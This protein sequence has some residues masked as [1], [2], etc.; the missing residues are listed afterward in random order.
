MKVRD[1]IGVVFLSFGISLITC[2]IYEFFKTHSFCLIA[3][4]KRIKRD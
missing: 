3:Q 2:E 4:T 1:I